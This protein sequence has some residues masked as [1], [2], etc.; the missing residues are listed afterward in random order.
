MREG[1]VKSDSE[2]MNLE[3]MI[4][5]YREK[6][7]KVEENRANIAEE[8]DRLN[9]TNGE[10]SREIE[11]LRSRIISVESSSREE[12]MNL[13]NRIEDFKK[14]SFD[15]EADR[16]RQESAKMAY[17]SQVKQLKE[18]IANNKTEL[19]R[20]YDLMKQRKSEFEEMLRNLENARR[21][22]SKLQRENQEL[23]AANNSSD[24]RQ[25]LYRKEIENLSRSYE[26]YRSSSER[27]SAE[28]ARKN[29][30]IVEKIE[31]YNLLKVKY[32]D[33]VNNLQKLERKLAEINKKSIY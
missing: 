4:N 23:A 18:I 16:L 3:T 19:D 9:L 21:E 12:I 28:L 29:I 17:E 1:Q 10:L 11:A 13:N 24:E 31:D 30:E 2:K 20:L 27:N 7:S 14:S 6:L 22:V 15:N 25:K 5:S 8:R 26:E 32:D 33:A